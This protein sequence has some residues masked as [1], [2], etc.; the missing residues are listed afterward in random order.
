MLASLRSLLAKEWSSLHEVSWSWLWDNVERLVQVNLATP[1]PYEAALT[2]LVASIDADTLY[3][4][5]AE[6]Y[7]KFFLAAPA[8]EDYFKQSNTYLHV[9]ADKV[10]AMTLDMYRDPIRSVD[11][12]SALGLR[13]VG[14]AIPTE[15]FGP[16]VTACVEVVQMQAGATEMVVEAFRWSLG[17]VASMLVR[18]IIEGSTIVMKAIN[19]NNRRAIRRAISCAPRGVRAGWMLKI[20]VGSQ[21]ISPLSWSIESG[22]VNAAGAMLE[23]LLTIRADRDRY[24]F[25][26][27]DLF[28]RHA[29]IFKRLTEEAPTLLPAFLDGLI[30][31]SRNQEAGMRRVNYYIKHLL[32]NED[33]TFSKTLEWLGKYNDPK[34]VCHPALVLLSDSIWTRLAARR[35]LYG[36]SWF[37]FTLILFTVSQSILENKKLPDG[38]NSEGE[39]IEIFAC[40]LVIYGGSMTQ[41][42]WVQG[43]KMFN[44]LKQK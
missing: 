30:W 6:I 32:V 36:K 26:M 11:D 13:H 8:G 19:S 10:I 41:L 7:S 37:F 40:R 24:Y 27:D 39:R 20:Q 1:R 42:I 44:A 29:D 2:K 34:I 15:L 18:T 22:A 31:R 4:L 9:I 5:R 43:G 38:S 16:F 35:F 28:A 23:D 33:G 17:L 14:Y 25:G 21:S 12:I 3:K